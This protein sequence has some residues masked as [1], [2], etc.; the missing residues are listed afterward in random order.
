MVKLVVKIVVKLV[1]DS[2]N[3][4]VKGNPKRINPG[5]TLV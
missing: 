3:L 1:V 5:I 4:L 2:T